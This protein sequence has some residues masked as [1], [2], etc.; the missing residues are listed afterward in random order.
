MNETHLALSHILCI[1]MKA[2]HWPDPFAIL[3]PPTPEQGLQTY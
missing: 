3:S 1:E 2:G